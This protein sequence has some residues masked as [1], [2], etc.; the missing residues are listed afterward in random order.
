MRA[1]VLISVITLIGMSVEATAQRL[2]ITEVIQHTL[3]TNP[4]IQASWREFLISQKDVTV[5]RS[6]YMPSVDVNASSFFVDRNYGLDQS[7]ME[8]QA[9]ISVSQ[10]IYDGFLSR[11]ETQSL[12]QAQV[13]RF[14]EFYS[15]AEQ[16]SLETTL[17]YLDMVMFR[18][19]LQISESNLK[20]HIDVYKQIEQSAQAGVARGADLEQINGRLSLAESNIITEQSNLHDVTARFMRLTGL[21]SPNDIAP[22]DVNLLPVQQHSIVQLL[23]K[24]Y[25]SNPDLLAAVYNIDSQAFRIESAEARYHPRVAFNASYGFQSRDQVG[26]NNTITEARV[27]IQLDYNLYRAGADEAQIEQAIEQQVQAKDIRLKACRD[28]QQTLHIA[29]ND[30]VNLERQLPALNDHMLASARVRTAYLGQFRLGQR[31]LLDLLDAENEAYESSRAYTQAKITQLKSFF[32]LLASQGELLNYLNVSR[33]SMPVPADI[34]A[35]PVEYDP[36]YICPANT[37]DYLVS[38]G[39]ALTRDTDGDGVTD[40]WDDCPDTTAGVDIDQYGC[41]LAKKETVNYAPI[42][43]ADFERLDVVKTMNVSVEFEHDSADYS[44]NISELMTPLLDTLAENPAY[45]V[46]IEGHASLQGNADYNKQLSLRRAKAIATWLIDQ[47][48]IDKG[49]VFEVGYG[50]ERPV[51]DA[52]TEQANRTNRR[53]VARIVMLP[54]EQDFETP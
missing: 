29:F 38:S 52:Q 4:D 13:V 28:I 15:Q 18:E 41:E 31:T 37:V 47:Q 25:A 24:A 2:T 22:V 21:Q 54:Q 36:T 35:R 6:D 27:G 19:L 43:T 11:S 5:A 34:A 1:V 40:L 49:R 26:L 42:N 14:Y 46:I 45:G 50:E 39:N 20:T 7:F 51:I 10:L 8:N 16:V 44:S 12:E 48:G 30:I 33:Q 53:I 3:D 9:R 32:R 23:H 17:A